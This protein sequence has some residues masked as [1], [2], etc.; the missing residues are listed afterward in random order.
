MKSCRF[1]PTVDE[2]NERVEKNFKLYQK[3]QFRFWEY[4]FFDLKEGKVSNPHSEVLSKSINDMRGAIPLGQLAIFSLHGADAYMCKDG[5]F[6]ETELKTIEIDE[7]KLIVGANDIIYYETKKLKRIPIESFFKVSFLVTT[8]HLRKS[9]IRH[10]FVVLRTKEK[11]EVIDAF[12]LPGD[13]IYREISKGDLSNPHKSVSLRTFLLEEKKEKVL[14]PHIGWENWKQKILDNNIYLLRQ[15]T[16]EDL[17]NSFANA[18]K[19]LRDEVAKFKN[20][21]K[22]LSSKLHKAKRLSGSLYTQIKKESE[23]IENINIQIEKLNE[24]KDLID[25]VIKSKALRNDK[26]EYMFSKIEQQ[27]FDFEE[28]IE[29]KNKAIINLFVKEEKEIKA[30]AVLRKLVQNQD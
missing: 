23:K 1:V 19:T 29:E 27:L 3:D 7:S 2:F 8:E 25:N 5:Q 28:K 12:Y 21:L 14:I 24:R 17:K 16:Q 22:I 20:S 26:V 18:R 13:I 10:T 9:K 6:I 30:N 11:G 15:M 4:N